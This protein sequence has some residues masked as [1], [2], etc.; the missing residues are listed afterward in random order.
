MT[1]NVREAACLGDRVVLF[2]RNPG[3]IRAEFA[4]N[5]PRARD[6]NSVQLAHYSTEIMAALKGFTAEEGKEVSE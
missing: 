5:L 3:R 6:I 4:V 1:H 2:S